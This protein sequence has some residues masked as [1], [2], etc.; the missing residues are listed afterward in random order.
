[1]T[2]AYAVNI[3]ERHHHRPIIKLILDS[4]WKI[5]LIIVALRRTNFA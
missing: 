3:Q 2:S 4:L 1:M 5:G